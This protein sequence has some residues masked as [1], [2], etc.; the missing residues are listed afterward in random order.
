MTAPGHCLWQLKKAAVVVS[1]PWPPSDISA[2]K[3]E[4]PV[5]SAFRGGP[6]L[7]EFLN[8]SEALSGVDGDA[9]ENLLNSSSVNAF[10]LGTYW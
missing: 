5:G 6:G 3:L 8:E 10:S 2:W 7:R 9:W 4:S 1:G